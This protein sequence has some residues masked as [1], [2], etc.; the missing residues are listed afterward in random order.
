[1]VKNDE[2][3][4]ETQDKDEMYK[5]VNIMPAIEMIEYERVTYVKEMEDYLKNLKKMK[6]SEAK[7]KSFENLVQSNII[8]E[9]GEFT[10]QYQYSKLAL[11]K[12]R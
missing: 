10:E 12:K 8:S 1:M 9:N 3:S 7:K 6:K 11:K 2:D 4:I 5:E